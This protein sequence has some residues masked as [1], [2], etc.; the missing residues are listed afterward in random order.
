MSVNVSRNCGIMV[1]S[2][3]NK[4]QAKES[5]TENYQEAQKR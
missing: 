1:L 5:T 2:E 3:K 4:R